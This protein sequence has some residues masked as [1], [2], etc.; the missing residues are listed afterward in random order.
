MREDTFKDLVGFLREELKLF[1]ASSKPSKE[2]TIPT[3]AVELLLV[4]LW[5]GNSFMFIVA[6]RDPTRRQYPDFDLKRFAAATCKYK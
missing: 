1:A 6:F 2:L 5:P 3:K 4:S